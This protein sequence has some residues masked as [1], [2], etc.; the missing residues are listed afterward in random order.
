[1]FGHC[2]HYMGDNRRRINKEV[3]E[4]IEE[5][6]GNTFTEKLLSWK[7]GQDSVS[8]DDVDEIVRNALRDELPE[9]I[10]NVMR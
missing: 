5:E 2:V 4:D 6:A 9:I 3:L 7:L 1:M 10:R 8:R